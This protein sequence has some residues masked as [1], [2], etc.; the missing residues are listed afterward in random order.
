MLVK[1]LA[2]VDHEQPSFRIPN[3][4]H[5]HYKDVLDRVKCDL[6]ERINAQ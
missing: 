1:T 5:E 3:L 4:F 6:R 2:E